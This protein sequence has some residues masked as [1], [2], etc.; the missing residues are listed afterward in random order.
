MEDLFSDE[1]KTLAVRLDAL[2]AKLQKVLKENRALRTEKGQLLEERRNLRQTIDRQREDS[3]ALQKQI[4]SSVIAASMTA[5][6][7]EVGALRDRIDAY[8]AELDKCIAV[9][10]ET[11]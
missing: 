10:Q 4:K 1:R 6:K 2:E 5:G 9:L 7:D 3:L 11:A 8:V